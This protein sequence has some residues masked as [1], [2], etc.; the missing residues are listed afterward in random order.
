MAGGGVSSTMFMPCLAPGAADMVGATSGPERKVRGPKAPAY[1]KQSREGHLLAQATGVI[2]YYPHIAKPNPFQKEVAVCGPALRT[3]QALDALNTVHSLH[4][5]AAM[6]VCGCVC[7]FCIHLFTNRT[8]SQV[9][10]KLKISAT[11]YGLGG[12]M[13]KDPNLP[14]WERWD[15][16]RAANE[17]KVRALF[18]WDMFPRSSTTK[19][20]HTLWFL[21]TP[22]MPSL[23]RSLPSFDKN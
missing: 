19:N 3:L 1:T 23:M 11:T 4:S 6:Y 15:H 10:T 20:C 17:D 7:D 9:A 21:I 12:D 13:G 18:D 8:W 2:C 14:C 5:T 16:Y 22:C